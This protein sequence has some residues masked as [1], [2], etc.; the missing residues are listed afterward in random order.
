[1]PRSSIL[2]TRA[3]VLVGSRFQSTVQTSNNEVKVVNE[4]QPFQGKRKASKF[5]PVNNKLRDISSQIRASV[6]SSSNDLTESIEILEEGLSYLREI[7][8]VGEGLSDETIFSI[9]QPILASIIDKS[10]DPSYNTNRSVNEIL[11]IF[12]SYNVAHAYHFTKAMVHELKSGEDRKVMYENVFDYWVKFI[13]YSKISNNPYVFK[14][15]RVLRE[16]G[17]NQH[18]I[19]NL[20]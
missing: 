11:D 17:F 16:N 18:D 20:A 9:F 8:Q 3:Q 1:M 4:K 10:L 7:Q 14:M 2:R 15:Y 5:K 19:K 12:I 6:N 13:E